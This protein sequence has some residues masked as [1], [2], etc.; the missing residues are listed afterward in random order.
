MF[1]ISSRQFYYFFMSSP[2]FCSKKMYI[3]RQNISQFWIFS[4]I[5]TFIVDLLYL[6]FQS[7]WNYYCKF[8][9]CFQNFI[10][11]WRRGKVRVIHWW[12]PRFSSF[13]DCGK[14]GQRKSRKERRKSSKRNRLRPIKPDLLQSHSDTVMY[15]LVL[16]VLINGL[17]R[18][19]NL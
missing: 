12:Q 15:T 6:D 11:A 4:I 3:N 1:D 18:L 13:T 14:V 9:S 19:Q 5:H 2:C 7:V 10:Y 16:W 8:Q 17:H